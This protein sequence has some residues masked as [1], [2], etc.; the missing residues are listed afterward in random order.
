[1]ALFL[2]M[3]LIFY[4]IT[5]DGFLRALLAQTNEEGKEGA[6][7]YL[8]CCLIPTMTNYPSLEKYYLAL[9]FVGQKL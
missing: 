5:L 4:T 8:S 9:V 3:P 1:M 2:A 7:F 6:L